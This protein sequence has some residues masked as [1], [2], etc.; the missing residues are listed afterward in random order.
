VVWSST[1]KCPPPGSSARQRVGWTKLRAGIGTGIKPPTG[2]EI[3]YTDNP[4]LKPERS[5]S[6]DA[7]VEQALGGSAAVFEATFFANRYDDLIVS[8]GTGLSGVSRYRTD[9]VANASAQGLETGVRW[10]GPHGLAARLVWTFLH[11]EVLGLDT[12]PSQGPGFFKVGDP[13]VRRPSQQ[14]FV[15]VTCAHA[16]QTFVTVGGRGHV[17]HRTELRRISRHQ[18]R[19]RRLPRRRHDRAPPERMADECGRPAIRRGV[20]YPAHARRRWA[21]ESTR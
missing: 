17:R 8:V 13:L 21:C 6:M 7:G 16:R 12:L 3:A 9:N 19:T 20:G 15:E 4:N 1:R 14:G 10:Q 5:V 18:P 2:F 11:T